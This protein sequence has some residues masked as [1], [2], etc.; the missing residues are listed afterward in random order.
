MLAIQIS[1]DF[2]TSFDPSKDSIHG[3]HEPDGTGLGFDVQIFRVMKYNGPQP[4]LS[5]L[6]IRRS[7]W[8]SSSWTRN[9]LG[10]AGTSPKTKGP[11]LL[12]MRK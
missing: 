2:L 3:A 7:Y 8:G 10:K 12:T 1:Y 4:Y 5:Q 9:L 11:I 6:S